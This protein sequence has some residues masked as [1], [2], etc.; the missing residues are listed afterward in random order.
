[1]VAFSKFSGLALVASAIAHPGEKHSPSKLKRD[2]AIRDAHAQMG[3]RSLAQCQNSAGAQALKQRSIQ[4]RADT[5]KALREK[6][7]I[8]KTRR[9]LA[10]LQDWEAQNHNYTGLSTNDMFTP[11]ENVFDAV[12][13]SNFLSIYGYTILTLAN[14]ETEHLLRLVARAY[15]W[16]ILCCG[17]VYALQHQGGRAL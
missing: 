14:V 2:L 15:S 9:D 12:C 8:K 13:L 5:V 7:G 1:M 17:R 4:R 10:A 6:R 11:I 3:A 16:P